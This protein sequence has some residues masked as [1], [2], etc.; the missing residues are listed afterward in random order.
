M[1]VRSRS[2]LVITVAALLFLYVPLLVVVLFSFHNTG[3][4]S[5][6]FTGF[7][8][9]WYRFVL[10]DPG[11]R[12]A[13][14]NSLFVAAWK[15]R[16]RLNPSAPARA[17]ALLERSGFAV[18]RRVS[19]FPSEDVGSIPQGRTYVSEQRSSRCREVVSVGGG[20]AGL[21]RSYHLRARDCDH[22]VLVRVGI[23]GHRHTKRGDSWRR[24]AA[25]ARHD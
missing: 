6:P 18:E 1:T 3:S 5:L 16:F 17:G 8:L 23:A 24:I 12:S 4:L 20:P 10:S 19:S 25:W 21:A 7:S 14:E 13:L 9:R 15:L 22:V 11:F 2:S